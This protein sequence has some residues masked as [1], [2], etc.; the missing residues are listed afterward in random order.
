MLL[1]DQFVIF[2]AGYSWITSDTSTPW[3][4]STHNPMPHSPIGLHTRN[5]QFHKCKCCHNEAFYDRELCVTFEYC[6]G[7]CRDK[8]LLDQYER[9]TESD[10]KKLEQSMKTRGNVSLP[11]PTPGH[12]CYSILSNIREKI[13]SIAVNDNASSSSVASSNER[14]QDARRT[15]IKD[16]IKQSYS[17]VVQ[18]KHRIILYFTVFMIKIPHYVIL[19]TKIQQLKYPLSFSFSFFFLFLILFYFIILGVIS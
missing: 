17:E 4:I 14:L 19:A 5:T 16:M 15:P 7:M 10:I 2:F 11:K 1:K 18:S 8:D 6:S 3:P 9:E 12:S 13:K